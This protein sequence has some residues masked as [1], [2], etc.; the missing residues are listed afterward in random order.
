M[1]VYLSPGVFTREIDLN[2]LPSA[3]GPLRPAFVGPAQKGPLNVATLITGAQQYLDTFGEPI[4]ESPLGYAV[5]GYL[6]EGDSC[7]V[8]RV[9]VEAEEGQ[10]DSLAEVAIDVSGERANGW[11]RIPLFSGID[12]GRINLREVDADNPMTFHAA[13]NGTVD[14]NDVDESDT[15]GPTTA[16]L[17]VSGVYTGD[18]D[19][20]F[21]LLITGAPTVSSGASV[22]GAAFQVIRNSDGEILV[23]GDL[24][25]GDHNGTSQVISLDNGLSV[26]VIVTDGLL[27]ANDTFSFA[28][29]P[30]NRKFTIAVEGESSPTEYTMPSA[31]YDSVADFVDAANALL[32]S[33]DYL[34]VEY[35][36]EDGETVIPQI[37]TETAGERVQLLG[38]S[39]W[40]LE[41]GS[42][43]Y[44]WD[45]PRSYLLGVDPGPYDITSQNNR[46]KMMLVGDEASAKPSRTSPMRWMRLA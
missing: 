26:Q 8:M 32:S 35:T 10:A 44:A 15:N 33:E 39:G 12:Y 38:T 36:M 9:G 41:V 6:E 34:F 16:T 42:Q 24:S 22:D 25:D 29:A 30:D 17:N 23:E 21:I 18:I 40:A 4:P 1:A 31:S 7:F 45:I 14:F 3:V 43:Q 5:L 2:V 13:S 19:D 20:S 37:R 11:G 28:V 46:V 27:E